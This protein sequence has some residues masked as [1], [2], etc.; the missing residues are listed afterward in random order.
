MVTYQFGCYCKHV[1][2]V[3]PLLGDLSL[4]YV[5]GRYGLVKT[6]AVLRGHAEILSVFGKKATHYKRISGEDNNVWCAM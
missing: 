6:I 1:G 2:N 4:C 5:D 3:M